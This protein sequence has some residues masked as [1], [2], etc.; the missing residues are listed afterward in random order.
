MDLN[1]IAELRKKAEDGT[2][3]DEESKEIEEIFKKAMKA[4]PEQK[5]QLENIING[6]PVESDPSDELYKYLIRLREGRSICCGE[7]GEKYNFDKLNMCKAC[8][9]VYCYK[10][11]WDSSKTHKKRCECGGEID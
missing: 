2:L 6:L 11:V 1:R 3:N 5:R 7:C 8:G 9:S 10:C 4:W